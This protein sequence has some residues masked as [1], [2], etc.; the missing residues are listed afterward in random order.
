MHHEVEELKATVTKMA[1]TQN[2]LM[3]IIADIHTKSRVTEEQQNKQDQLLEE[4]MAAAQANAARQGTRSRSVTEEEEEEEQE[5]AEMESQP[6]P[7]GERPVISKKVG[8]G[9]R[10]IG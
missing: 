9:P 7:Q 2:T 6:E 8:S 5:E 10:W 4:I 1:E 3:K